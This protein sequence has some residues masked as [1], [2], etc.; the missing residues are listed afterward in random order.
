MVWGGEVVW[1]GA[2]G[3]QGEGGVWGR[4]GGGGG[5][6]PP[7]RT[8]HHTK[9]NYL[10]IWEPRSKVLGLGFREGLGIRDQG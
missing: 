5:V 2:G 1:G 6:V 9:K 4:F 7:L 8:R 3:Q 10:R